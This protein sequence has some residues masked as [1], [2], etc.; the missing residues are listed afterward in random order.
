MQSVGVVRAVEAE[1]PADRADREVLRVGHGRFVGD[2]ADVVLH[3]IAAVVLVRR[4]A[5]RRADVPSAVLSRRTRPSRTCRSSGAC[6]TTV[7]GVVAR[8]C[9]H[10]GDD[11]R[12]VGRARSAAVHASGGTPP[13]PLVDPARPCSASSRSSPRRV[14]VTPSKLEDRACDR[15]RTRRRRRRARRH[16][17]SLRAS[18]AAAVHCRR[19]HHRRRYRR[20]HSQRRQA[21]LHRA[22]ARTASIANAM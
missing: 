5:V 15:S 4:V 8:R 12:D 21:W 22:S 6:V 1:A 7:I 3:D 20:R 10:A 2:P 11:R 14:S 16:A 17:A 9:L 13:L 19:R 18:V